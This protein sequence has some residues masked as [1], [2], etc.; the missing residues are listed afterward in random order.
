MSDAA[1]NFP[2]E[3]NPVP[4]NPANGAAGGDIS[5][6]IPTFDPIPA[7]TPTPPTP[8]AET[9]NDAYHI[10]VSPQPVSGIF[11]HPTTEPSI[12]VGGETNLSPTPASPGGGVTTATILPSN[13]TGTDLVS[14]PSSGGG[15]RFILPA[16]VGALFFLALVAGGII[17]FRQQGASEE[18]ANTAQTTPSPTPESTT[19]PTTT[20]QNNEFNFTVDYP[21]SWD[22]KE[23]TLGNVVTFTDP[24]AA[25]TTVSRIGVRTES[26]TK[27]LKTYVDGLNKLSSQ[28]YTGFSTINSTP[29][30]VDSL[31]AL[32]L[33]NTYVKGGNTINMLQLVVVKGGKA[34]VVTAEA[35]E[36]NF[37]TLKP[38]YNQILAS[39]NF[40]D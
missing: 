2:T 3:P 35:E 11:T 22:Q 30:T 33:E 39:L 1:P 18:T 19:L 23:T 28:L 14:Y 10:P 21:L 32:Q 31:E 40:A 36:S 26:T 9:T 24:T 8:I 27:E 25:A 13:Q 16:V 38:T 4:A 5:A 37:T 20:Y 7:P 12:A 29:T 34:Y 17:F 6:P 15:R